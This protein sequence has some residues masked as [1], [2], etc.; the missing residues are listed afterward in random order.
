MA[1]KRPLQGMTAVKH[2]SKLRRRLGS[3]FFI[4]KRWCKWLFRLSELRL[5]LS[6]EPLPYLVFEHQ[7]ILLRPLQGLDMQLQINKVKNLSLAAAKINGILIPPGKTFSFWFQ[8]GKPTAYKGYLNGLVLLNGQIGQ[9]IAGGLC[10]MGNLLHWMALHSDLTIT[11][12]WRH[13]YDA[14]PDQN[15]T[16]PFGSGATLS[17][18]YLD[19]CLTNN[20]ETE[21]Q[22]CIWLTE[23]DLCG[24]IR[25]AKAPKFKHKVIETDHQIVLEP[26]GGYSRHNVLTRQTFDQSTG[27][28]VHE[29]V[30]CQ[31]HAL[32]CYQPFL[33]GG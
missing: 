13:S 18:N 29:A 3:Y 27:Q 17:Y 4:A 19:L 25:Y 5:S 26:W 8:V 30:A 10:Q 1:N 23:T 9:G 11:E 2:R 31:N 16:I 21:M 6:P 24:A 7:S 28:L 32:L 12:R 22:I 15:R 20:T 14:F 33:N